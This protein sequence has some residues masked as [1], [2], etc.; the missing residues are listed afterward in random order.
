MIAIIQTVPEQTMCGSVNDIQS[1][2]HPIALNSLKSHSLTAVADDS[3]GQQTMRHKWYL[4]GHV[5]R[6]WDSLLK[7]KMS[8]HST[9]VSELSNT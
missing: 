3:K 9:I 8:R 4:I 2:L 5:S 7:L 6:F 1:I